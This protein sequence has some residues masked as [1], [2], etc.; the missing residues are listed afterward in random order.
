MDQSVVSVIF[1]LIRWGFSRAVMAFLRSYK[2]SLLCVRG[3]IGSQTIMLLLAKP[4]CDSCPSQHSD[5][6]NTVVIFNCI[7][8]IIM[9]KCKKEVLLITW[10]PKCQCLCLKVSGDLVLCNSCKETND[11]NSKSYFLSIVGTYYI[12]MKMSGSTLCF[13]CSRFLK[14]ACNFWGKYGILYQS[15]R[16]WLTNAIRNRLFPS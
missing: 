5:T 15:H 11:L 4:Y 6:K 10:P 2:R 14:Y 3:G 1:L 13:W 16:L 8:I 12:N 9:P 7:I